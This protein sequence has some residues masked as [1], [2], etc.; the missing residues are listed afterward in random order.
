MTHPPGRQGM[1]WLRGHMGAP[2]QSADN[3]FTSFKSLA[4][5]SADSLFRTAGLAST[6]SL[7]STRSANNF[8]ICIWQGQSKRQKMGID[9][10]H[11]LYRLASP[12]QRT[13]SMQPAGHLLIRLRIHRECGMNTLQSS[14]A[15]YHMQQSGRSLSIIPGLPST[16]RLHA[17]QS[18]AVWALQLGH[19][20]PTPPA[21]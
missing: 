16:S 7:D 14:P 5:A 10:G 3:V 9:F 8:L 12:S 1:Q 2:T 17:P 18:P 4:A 19:H 13:A 21:P 6:V 20:A 11:L 15:H